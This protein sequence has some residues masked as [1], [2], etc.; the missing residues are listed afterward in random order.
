M[1]KQLIALCSFLAFITFAQAQNSGQFGLRGGASLGHYSLSTNGYSF[2]FANQLQ[3]FGR[4][5]YN[6]PSA[7]RT[8]LQMEAGV[9]QRSLNMWLPGEIGFPA[10]PRISLTNVETALLIRH[11]IPLGVSSSM[12]F[13]GGP[14]ATYTL[15]ASS[16][17]G[18]NSAPID[19][20]TSGI[21]RFD[22]GVEVGAGINF[23][24][25]NQY[26][27][28]IRYGR[29]FNSLV[30]QDGNTKL[31]HQQLSLGLNYRF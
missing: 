27:L 5:T 9:G 25:R 12:H 15:A 18:N 14:I 30:P 16:R 2:G 3:A 20:P 26:G 28:E 21:E 6:S 19:L 10:A 8:S 11:E 29:G 13:I 1:K 22:I 31:T 7:S 24:F 17:A 4:L 23:G